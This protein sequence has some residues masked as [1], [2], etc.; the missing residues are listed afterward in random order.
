MPASYGFSDIVIRLAGRL[1]QRRRSPHVEATM[2]LYN[3]RLG[4]LLIAGVLMIPAVAGAQNLAVTGGANINPDQ[5]YVGAKYD[6]PLLD[7]V[8]L[9]PSVDVG[10]GNDAKLIAG[11]FEATYRHPL[12]RRSPWTLVAGGGP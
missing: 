12:S 10:F 11:N 8:W 6:W 5:V 3:R 1:N 7:R 4:M 2:F 9:E